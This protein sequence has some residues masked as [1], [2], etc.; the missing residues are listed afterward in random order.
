L[1]E[2]SAEKAQVERLRRDNAELEQQVSLSILMPWDDVLL[3]EPC[4]S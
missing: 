1:G 4:A 3:Y 2:L